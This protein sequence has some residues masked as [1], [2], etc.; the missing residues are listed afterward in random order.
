MH[1]T[2][3]LNKNLG[4]TFG[5]CQNGLEILYVTP[6]GSAGWD[7]ISTFGYRGV[8]STRLVFSRY[9]ALKRREKVQPGALS[10]IMPYTTCTV[11]AASAKKENEATLDHQQGRAF[12]FP[13]I[14]GM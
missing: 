5:R 6:W 4:I 11:L 12:F 7:K 8:Y 14:V 2:C 1:G 10:D 9:N 3:G 13:K